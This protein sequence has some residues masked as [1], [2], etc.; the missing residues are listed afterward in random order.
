MMLAPSSSVL[1]IFA[2]LVVIVHLVYKRRWLNRLRGCK[3]PP[4]PRRLPIVG[5]LFDLPNTEQP[6]TVYNEWADVYGDMVFTQVMNTPMLLVSSTEVAFD[7]LDKR[8]AIYSDRIASVMNELTA[9]DFNVGFMPY[10]QRWRNIRRKVHEY[11]N[12]TVTANHRDT[13]TQEVHAFLRRCLA[14]QGK[15]LNPLLVRQ[16]VS[17]IIANTVYGIEIKDMNH[18]YIKLVTQARTVVDTMKKPGKFWLD[19][20]PLLRY[21]PTWAPGAAGVKYAARVRPSVEAMLNIPFDNI[22]VETDPKESIALDMIKKLADVHN[23]EK[24][25]IEERCA[26]DASAMAYSGFVAGSDTSYSLIQLFL[27]LMATYPHIQQKAQEEL[28]TVVGP[29]RLPTCEDR[30]SLP[31]I[32]AI[33]LECMRWRPIVPLGVS[34]RL[35]EDDYYKEYFIP[36]GTLVIPFVWRMLHDPREYSE[37]EKFNPDRFI[38]NGILSN[39]VR[40]PNIVAFGFGRRICPGRYFAMD[41][42]FLTMASILHAYNVLPSLDEKGNE[43]NPMPKWLGAHVSRPEPLHYMLVSQSEASEKLVRATAI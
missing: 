12:L 2:I 7:L 28:R 29:D 30:D 25:V 24:R 17:G 36:A 9:W 32:Q 40:D 8:S 18:E 21:V 26:K 4:G 10:G 13:Q 15:Q 19:Y 22:K 16:L 37:P 20:M 35:T 38:K 42:A 1:A 41:T 27:C 43:L 34:H 33:F 39:E 6:W 31:Y 3:L 23:P 14:E 11:F 5:N